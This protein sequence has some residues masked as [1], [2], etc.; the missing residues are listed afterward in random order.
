[1]EYPYEGFVN[2]L[3]CRSCPRKYTQNLDEKSTFCAF[4]EAFQVI[5][6]PSFG[7]YGACGLS[8]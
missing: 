4:L 7:A 8:W 2:I 6:T 3:C 5:Q 1:M